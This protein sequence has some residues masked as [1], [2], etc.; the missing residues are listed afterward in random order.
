MRL[1]V[2]AGAFAVATVLGNACSTPV[3][4]NPSSSLL[5]V[6]FGFGG[7]SLVGALS[8]FVDSLYAEPLLGMAWNGRPQPRLALEWEWRD[9][10]RMLRLRLRQDVVFHDGSPLTA[11]TVAASLQRRREDLGFKRVVS[12]ESEGK[13]IVVIRLQKPD[14]FLLGELSTG[15]IKIGDGETLGT[16]PFKIRSREPETVLDAFQKYYQGP[17]S[18]HRVVVRTYETPRAAWAATMRGDVSF[19]YEVNRDAIG[20]VEAG[21]KVK[22]FPYAR[23][24][25]V[26]LVF[27][28][29]HP[30]LGRRE[31][32]QAINEAIDRQAIVR[33]ALNGRGQPADGPIWPYHW[34][35]N[36]GNRS[37][38]YN[39]EAARLRLESAGF[40]VEDPGGGDMPRRLKFQCL[41]WREDVQYE[42]IALVVQKQLFEVGIDV[43][44]VPVTLKELAERLGSGNFEAVLSQMTSSRSLE[45]MYWFWRSDAGFH[46]TG[47]TAADSAL[48]MMRGAQSDDET[49]IAVADLQRILYEDPPA[50]FLVRLEGAR[51]VE[52]SFVVPA[53]EP[54]RDILGSLRLWK[55]RNAARAR[56]SQ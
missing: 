12:V 17:P 32:R 8:N 10:G 31:V 54:G 27:N 20:F 1:C 36:S 5:T 15:T 50:A 14:A 34:A 42:R 28:I 26:P 7:T 2:L 29:K 51:A 43:E 46:R 47:Y 48:D 13:D 9:G 25:Y 16:G 38:T 33:T 45:W 11:E 4:A 37:Y 24:Y 44:M 40:T 30:T 23:P 18:I 21:S 55:P 56:A 53:E 39:P 35:Y 3:P 19:L 52:D 22:T 6:G 41:F 49:R